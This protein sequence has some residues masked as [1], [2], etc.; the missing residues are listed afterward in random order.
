MLIF[1]DVFR[2][3]DH[4]YIIYCIY[5]NI[6]RIVDMGN[7]GVIDFSQATRNKIEDKVQIII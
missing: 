3:C 2:E 1:K 7:I 5:T 6:T 4:I